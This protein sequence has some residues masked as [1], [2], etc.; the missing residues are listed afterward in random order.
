MQKDKENVG[1]Y[2]EKIALI[3]DGLQKLFPDGKQAIVFELDTEDFKKIQTNFRDVDKMYKRFQ[4]DVSGVECV[5]IDKNLYEELDNLKTEEEQKKNSEIPEI[6]KE[7]FWTK[8]KNLF[9]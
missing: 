2:L 3:C 4:V 9:S 8:F 6:K 1:D 5:F 7:K